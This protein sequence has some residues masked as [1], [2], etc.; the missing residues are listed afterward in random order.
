[1]TPDLRRNLLT[2]AVAS[3]LAI[4]GAELVLTFWPLPSVADRLYDRRERA[5]RLR[6]RD[7]DPR[8]RAQVVH[9]LRAQGLD[10]WPSLAGGRTIGLK[11]RSTDGPLVHPLGNISSVLTVMC[12]EDGPWIL[13]R[14]DEHGFGNP[15][16]QWRLPRAEL[17]LIG[18]SFTQGQCVHV[19]DAYPSLVRAR[20]PA[21]IVTGTPNAGP[22]SELGMLREFIAPLKP[23]RLL[24]LYYEGNDLTD[25][26][27]EKRTPLLP[28]YLEPEFTQHLAGRQGAV[29]STLKAYA[30]AIDA[31]PQALPEPAFRWSLGVVL[32]RLTLSSLRQ[33]LRVLRRNPPDPCCDLAMFTRILERAMA[34]AGAWGGR[35]TFVYLPAWTTLTGRPRMHQAPSNQ[36]DSV[37]AIVRRLGLPLLDLRDS[38]PRYAPGDSLIPFEDGHFTVRGH[39]IV[40]DILLRYLAA[41]APAA[42]GR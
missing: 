39:A 38:L 13:Y 42:A 8:T 35:I 3:L 32:D 40:A 26:E 18:D 33:S 2:A 23:A 24:W 20:Y 27:A 16:G 14:T 25:L 1:M 29:D 5:E 9:E 22:L 19:A 7:A 36:V 21:T 6:G 17:A 4:Y 10:A 37:R 28:R 11:L 34:D 15:P 41:A 30:L 12:V 31:S